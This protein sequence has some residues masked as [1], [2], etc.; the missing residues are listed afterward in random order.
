[1]YYLR[2]SHPKF[3]MDFGGDNLPYTIGIALLVAL[4]VGLAIVMAKKPK[5]F[6]KKDDT[7]KFDQKRMLIFYVSIALV[8][9]FLGLKYSG[10]LNSMMQ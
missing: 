4:L 2:A 3:G 8:L 9:L 7:T 6:M 1:M 10:A 5:W